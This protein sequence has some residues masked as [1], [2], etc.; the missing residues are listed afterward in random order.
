MKEISSNFYVSF[1]YIAHIV[2]KIGF[3]E[4]NW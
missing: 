4:T 2:R 1:H 3:A